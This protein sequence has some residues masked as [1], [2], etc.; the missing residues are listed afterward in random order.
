MTDQAT[1]N[2]IHS[3]WPSLAKATSFLVEFTTPILK[4]FH[5]N[6][7]KLSFNSMPDFESW[8]ESLGNNA[9]GWKIKYYKGLGTSSPQEGR[10]YFRDLVKHKKDFV[11]EDDHD[12]DAIKLAFS[13]KMAKDRK[14]WIRGF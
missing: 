10:E 5:L 12:G 14:N 9:Y 2:F 1:D 13:K 11:W 7:T 3:F 6:G 4:A 8:K